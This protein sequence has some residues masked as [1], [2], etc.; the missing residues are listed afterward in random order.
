MFSVLCSVLVAIQHGF[1]MLRVH[2][3]RLD[4][5]AF[6]MPAV[7]ALFC[8][9]TR[10]LDREVHRVASTAAWAG[11]PGRHLFHRNCRRKTISAQA[12]VWAA[13]FAVASAH[14]GKAKLLL[15]GSSTYGRLRTRASRSLCNENW[16]FPTERRCLIR[17][18]RVAW[19]PRLRRNLS[20]ARSIWRSRQ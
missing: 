14:D 8:Q 13:S 2:L 12:V 15:S 6:L 3:Q 4:S 9:S 10:G 18:L 20:V 16:G 5:T 17:S 19:P 1:P 11:A 7:A